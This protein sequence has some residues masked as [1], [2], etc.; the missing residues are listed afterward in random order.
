MISQKDVATVLQIASI[1]LENP[2]MRDEIA[3]RLD[4]S[5]EEV[6]RIAQ[7]INDTI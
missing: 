6:E 4:L 5:I 7:D 2:T 3:N 1:A